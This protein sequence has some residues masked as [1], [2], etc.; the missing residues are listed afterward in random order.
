LAKIYDSIKT[1]RIVVAEVSRINANVYYELGYAHAR[2]KPTILI[3]KNIK[4]SPFDTKGFNHIIYTN[5]V[6]LKKQLKDT[7]KAILMN[8]ALRD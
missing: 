4:S 2:E 1:S 7:L 5:I 8:G 3:T 6:D